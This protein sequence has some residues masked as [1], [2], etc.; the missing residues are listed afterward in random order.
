ME[1]K[2]GNQIR[3]ERHEE[4]KKV[5]DIVCP[6]QNCGYTAFLNQIT[7]L[8]HLKSRHIRWFK[9]K[10]KNKQLNQILANLGLDHQELRPIHEIQEIPHFDHGNSIE[11]PAENMSQEE[12]G[13]VLNLPAQKTKPMLAEYHRNVSNKN[14]LFSHRFVF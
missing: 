10:E 14:E 12:E 6:V 5:K 1:R 13:D 7:F 8:N 11:E 9:E 2:S 3:K 4:R